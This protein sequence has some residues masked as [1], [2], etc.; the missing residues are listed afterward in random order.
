MATTTTFTQILFQKDP[1]VI[2]SVYTGF[3]FSG[4]VAPV[5]SLSANSGGAY[6]AVSPINNAGSTLHLF[7][8]TGSQLK[9]R[10]VNDTTTTIY[11]YNLVVNP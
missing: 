8:T 2:G 7:S 4:A 6:E 5:V 10:I 11:H 3:W 1:V 9:L